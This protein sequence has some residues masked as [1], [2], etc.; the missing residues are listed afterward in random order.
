MVRTRSA[1]IAAF[2][3][4][5]A[6]QPGC[7]YDPA[8]KLLTPA[9]PTQEE[10]RKILAGVWEYRD[11]AV[12][13]QLALDENG[14]GDYAWKNG[15]FLTTSLRNGFWRG[16]WSQVD[17]D[18][19]G[20]FEV[21]LSDDYLEGEGRWWYTRIGSDTAPLEPGGTF[22]LTRDTPEFGAHQIKNPS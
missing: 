16:K 7:S 10:P 13:Y 5:A 21:K 17:N 9:A 20:E 3:L 19:E 8:V 18:R 4:A 11:V 15:S 14:N 22:Y 6:V 2:V 1:L 12:A